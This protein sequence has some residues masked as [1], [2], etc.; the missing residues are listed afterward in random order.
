VQPWTKI[1]YDRTIQ[2]IVD[3]LFPTE[4]KKIQPD[5]ITGSSAALTASSAAVATSDSNSPMK[6]KEFDENDAKKFEIQSSEGK[7]VALPMI[8]A[9]ELIATSESRPEKR[10]EHPGKDSKITDKRT[11]LSTDVETGD[12]EVRVVCVQEYCHLAYTCVFNTNIFDHFLR[13][14]YRASYNYRKE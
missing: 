4:V 7:S 5:E 11:K 9:N 6:D 8:E 10:K 3:K 13:H 1:I 12:F 14:C 2:A